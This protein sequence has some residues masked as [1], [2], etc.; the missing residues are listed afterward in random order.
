MKRIAFLLIFQ[1]ARIGAAE[2]FL[3]KFVAEAF[4]SLGYFFVD[5]LFVLC[6]LIFN[7]HVCAVAFLGVAV[8]DEG[9]VESVHV[10]G[11][12]PN[13]GVHEDGGV[14]SDDVLVEEHHGLPPVLFDVVF[15]FDAVLSVVIDS[16]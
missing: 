4:A 16:A 13:S 2:L 6:N 12:F 1:D 11:S 3:V 15:Q 14:D 5:F 7:E 9:V 10:S 8:V